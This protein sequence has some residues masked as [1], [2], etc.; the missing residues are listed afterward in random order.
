MTVVYVLH[1]LQGLRNYADDTE[2]HKRWQEVKSIAKS[3]AMDYIEKAT[4]VKVPRNAM[5]DMQVNAVR[6]VDCSQGSTI[7]PCWGHL[8]IHGAVHQA[9]TFDV[10][11]FGI[12]LKWVSEYDC[13][14]QRRDSLFPRKLIS[15]HA[16]GT[17]LDSTAN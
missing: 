6:T 12:H 17:L 4:G 11:A 10:H 13:P 8:F 2:L 16:L 3:K 15:K 9:V 14:E 7:V 5:L 1:K